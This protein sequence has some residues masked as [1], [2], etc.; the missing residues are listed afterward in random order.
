[1]RRARLLLPVAVTAV[2]CWV[3]LREVDVTALGRLLTRVDRPLL[4]AF[5]V[6]GV[7]GLLVRTLRYGVLLGGRAPF[8]PLML[9]TAAR[10]FLVDLLPAR[11]G[12]LSYVYLLNRR[13]GVP[14]EPVLSSF[15]LSFVYDLLAMALLIAVALT[16]EFGRFRGADTLALLLAVFAAG[17]VTAF[18]L[19]GP[20]L[21]FAAGIVRRLGRPIAL[22]AA[23]LLARTAVE[24]V[25]AGGPARVSGILALSFLIRLLK[26]GA[27]WMLLL[28]VL[29]ERGTTAADLPFWTVFLGIAGAELSATLPIHGIAGF[30][31]YEAAWTIGFTQLGVDRETAILS[32][33]ATHLLSQAW[34]YSTGIVAL[35]VVLGWRGPVDRVSGD[36]R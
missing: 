18:A 35:G 17:S 26:F 28:A 15:L 2:L 36:A 6:L 10:N 23:D 11:V 13:V 24:I 16:L 21:D 34:D 19:L 4:G 27:Y 31:T 8:L 29:H 12:S 32:G 30:G 20:S 33:F 22:K 3:L 1:M 25:A 9:V 7:L 5:A 14:I